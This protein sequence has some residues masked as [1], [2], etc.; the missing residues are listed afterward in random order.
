[1]KKILLLIVAVFSLLFCSC[2]SNSFTMCVQQNFKNEY[3]IHF[4]TFRGT[5][6]TKIRNELDGDGT[7]E[8]TASLEEGSMNVYY[9]VNGKEELLFTIEAGQS[10][11]D[12]GGYITGDGNVKIIMKTIEP[13]KNG[14]F[15]FKLVTEKKE[16]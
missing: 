3:T 16:A 4:G 9:E 14:E 1:M 7:I 6:S 13:C 12:Q 11:S 10:L 5:K 8:Y 15:D 2:E